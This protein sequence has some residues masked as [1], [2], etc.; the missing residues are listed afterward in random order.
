MVAV[1]NNRISMVRT[2]YSTG[3]AI[4]KPTQIIDELCDEQPSG[5]G[6]FVYLKPG[7][8]IRDNDID[9]VAQHYR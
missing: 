3:N 4:P 2:T 5:G 1:G 7:W 9:S 6:W 8:A